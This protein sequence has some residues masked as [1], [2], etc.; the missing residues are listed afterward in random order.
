VYLLGVQPG[1]VVRHNLIHDITGN[2]SGIVLDNSSAG[3]LV[4]N[5]I[6]HHVASSGLL[7]NYND[8]GNIVQNNVFALASQA[9]M[10]RSGDAGKVDQTGIF[11]RNIFYYDGAKGRLF[12]PDKWP[13]YDIVVD[14]NLY[15][16]A[17][18]KPPKFLDFDFDQWKS[19]GL[20]RNSIV[21]DPLFVDPQKGDFRLRPESPAFRLGFRPIDLSSVG[22]RQQTT[23]GPE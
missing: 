22:V 7:F 16:D 20:D 13:N 3:I 8:Q 14:Y 19:K 11:Y 9:L 6:V 2:G 15:F 4:E 21:A 10:N 23:K 12:D 1:T 18:G 17:S 5:N